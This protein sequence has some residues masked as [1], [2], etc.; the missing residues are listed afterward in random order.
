ML[1]RTQYAAITDIVD[2]YAMIRSTYL[3]FDK[4]LLEKTISRQLCRGYWTA[5][6]SNHTFEVAQTVTRIFGRPYGSERNVNIS[7]YIRLSR[8][9]TL[10]PCA[11]EINN[12]RWLSVCMPMIKRKEASSIVSGTKLLFIGDSHSR[13]LSS[14]FAAWICN[15]ERTREHRG[16]SIDSGRNNSICRNLILDYVDS[17]PHCLPNLVPNSGKYDIVIMNCAHHMAAYCW[18]EDHVCEHY[19]NEQYAEMIQNIANTVLNNK[20]AKSEF[21]WMEGNV[22]PISNSDS[23]IKDNDWRTIHRL[24]NFNRIA[25]EVFRNYSYDIM[26]TFASTLPLS[27]K[28]CDFAH[29]TA[30]EALMPQFQWI[31]RRILML[32]SDNL[33]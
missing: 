5:F 10:Q 3:I 16:F 8:A 17:S 6:T 22:I 27:D 12:Y 7:T 28:L 24:Q 29:Y 25:S 31:L 18:P 9:P 26:P 13:V 21:V 23:C 32:K 11:N 15:F 2:E 33:R 19:R 14:S 1:L 30:P 20:L 4:I